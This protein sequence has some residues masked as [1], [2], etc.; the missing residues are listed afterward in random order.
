[1]REQRLKADMSRANKEIQYYQEKAEMA[2]NLNRMEERRKSK[3]AKQTAQSDS[4]GQND[5][6]DDDGKEKVENKD[7]VIKK[8]KMKNFEKQVKYA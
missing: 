4:E 2:I 7:V 1:M 3:L 6:N 8:K 5:S